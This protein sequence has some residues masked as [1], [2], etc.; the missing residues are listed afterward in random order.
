MTSALVKKLLYMKYCPNLWT[1][2]VINI[3]GNTKIS[4]FLTEGVK[5]TCYGFMILI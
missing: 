2:V 3:R 4:K 1:S 5:K